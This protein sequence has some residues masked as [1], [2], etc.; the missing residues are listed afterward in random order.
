LLCCNIVHLGSIPIVL[1][2]AGVSKSAHFFSLNE[3]AVLL[4]WASMS[5]NFISHD[6]HFYKAHYSHNHQMML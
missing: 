4:P 5:R 1:P 3:L 6:P 2:T